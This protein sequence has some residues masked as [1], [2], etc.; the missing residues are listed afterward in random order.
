MK[1]QT[2]TKL[3]LI[4]FALSFINCQDEV[5]ETS[6]ETNKEHQETNFKIDKLNFEHL[7]QDVSFQALTANFNISQPTFNPK[8]GTYQSQA[9]TSGSSNNDDHWIDMSVVNKIETE[10]YVSYTMR[11][12][13]PLDTSG[14]LSN[15]VIQERYGVEEIFTIRYTDGSNSRTTGEGGMNM[16]PGIIPYDG[17]DDYP[18]NDDSSGG[19]GYVYVCRTVSG[20]VQE[21]PCT[22]GTRHLVNDPRECPCQVT[23]QSCERAHYGFIPR[24]VCGYEYTDGNGNTTWN[25]NN[26]DTGN[27][28]NG[29][30]D[31][32]VLDD[33][34]TDKVGLLIPE[35]EFLPLVDC[36]EPNDAQ[37]KWLNEQNR[38]EGS[39]ELLNIWAYV[40]PR[41]TNDCNE[42]RF[43]LKEV[44]DADINGILIAAFPFVKYPEG[45][46]YVSLYPKLTEYLK[47][48][49]PKVAN[50]PKIV[51]AINE[52][53]QLPNDEIKNALKWG[54]GPILHVQQLNNY[55][56]CSTCGSDTVGYFDKNNPT[57]IYID[58]DY[59]NLIENGNVTETDDDAY[60]FFLG[61][62]ILHELVHWG[63]H[64]NESFTYDGEE[65]RHFEYRVYNANVNPDNARLILDRYED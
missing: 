47:N 63:E 42:K 53:T 59:V 39:N 52:F 62:T 4:L 31:E 22:G 5:I 43:F 12:V 13:E 40:N 27:T 6:S 49:I 11:L 23:I 41:D 25:P 17:W 48:Q 54:E 51:N 7:E 33:V 65:G 3:F 61:T 37:L 18:D 56:G 57:N 1:H 26:N 34:Y 64:N 44:I 46:S 35:D 45:S 2:F 10:N 14:A 50:I 60:I 19:D 15:I 21:I 28:G 29:S 16:K 32:P 38:Q 30:P 8:K 9:R 55:P 36:I 20:E 58:V 24:E